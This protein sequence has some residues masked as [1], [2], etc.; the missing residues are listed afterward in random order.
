MPAV[1]AGEKARNLI[2][3]L[4]GVE[5]IA[6][7]PRPHCVVLRRDLVLAGFNHRP[8]KRQRVGKPAQFVKRNRVVGTR[9]IVEVGAERIVPLPPFDFRRGHRLERLQ[10]PEPGVRRDA[11]DHVARRVGEAGENAW[12]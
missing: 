3:I 10:R 2:D 1:R 9:D 4:R 5:R 12:G 6:M 11:S 8:Q 7:R